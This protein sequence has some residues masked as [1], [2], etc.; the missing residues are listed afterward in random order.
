MNDGPSNREAAKARVKELLADPKH[1][2][3]K[4]SPED[5][6][7]VDAEIEPMKEDD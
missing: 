6:E 3:A 4:G 7:T 1:R 5:T 2:K